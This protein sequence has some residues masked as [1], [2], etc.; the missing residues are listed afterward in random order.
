MN[1]RN[2]L[3]ARL[4]GGFV[5]AVALAGLAAPGAAQ[6]A[7]PASGGSPQVAAASDVRAAAA[8]WRT[9]STHRTA[10]TCQAAKARLELSTPWVLRCQS[11]GLFTH[12]LQRYS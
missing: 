12:R 9:I 11:A 10:L 4:T 2:T 3:R 6:A 5:A 8:S 7:T 1:Q